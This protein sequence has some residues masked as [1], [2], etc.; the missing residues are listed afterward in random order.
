VYDHG[1]GGGFW[2]DDDAGGNRYVSA[3]AWWGEDVIPRIRWRIVMS[4]NVLAKY[5]KTTTEGGEIPPGYGISHYEQGF[6]CAVLYPIPLNLIVGAWRFKWHVMCPPWRFTEWRAAR[7]EQRV[8]ESFRRGVAI[9]RMDAGIH[10]YRDNSGDPAYRLGRD[11]AG[12]VG[13][14]YVDARGD[15]WVSDGKGWIAFHFQQ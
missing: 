10:R 12:A 2:R 14:V 15:E 7:V 11:P 6:D 13:A 1:D 8:E 5:R 4:G 3:K 9:A